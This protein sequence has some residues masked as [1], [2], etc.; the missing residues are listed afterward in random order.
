MLYLLKFTH[1]CH[2]SNLV[3]NHHYQ[4]DLIVVELPS[5]YSL[6]LHKLLQE[7]LQK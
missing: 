4:Q 5:I 1:I 2:I 3:L 6:Q 7:F